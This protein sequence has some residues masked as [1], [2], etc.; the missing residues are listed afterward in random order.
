[1]DAASIATGKVGLR[2][3]QQHGYAA[4]KGLHF[5]RAPGVGHGLALGAAQQQ[6]V[7]L[8]ERQRGRHG[9]GVFGVGV[10]G[11]QQAGARAGVHQ[12]D[13]AVRRVAQV[14]HPAHVQQLLQ[15]WVQQRRGHK[16]HAPRRKRCDGGCWGNTQCRQHLGG[17]DSAAL[18]GRAVHQHRPAFARQQQREQG[19]EH[20][21]FAGPV[22]AGNGDERLV[23]CRYVVQTGGGGVQKTGHLLGRFALD[24]HGQAKGAH[25][26]VGHAAV[27]QLAPQVGGLFAAECAR[28]VFAT[29]DF[30]EVDAYAH[31]GI[32][33]EGCEREAMSL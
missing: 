27:E 8:N 28:A 5:G 33:G 6:R 4:Q 10:A 2:L 18:R 21:Q 32:V 12:L 31:G 30:L 7:G 25:L 16:G 1:M 9:G 11:H 3:L 13:Q 22:V 24:A 29:P 15:P 19:G 20:G 17:E 14:N 26:Q 23:A